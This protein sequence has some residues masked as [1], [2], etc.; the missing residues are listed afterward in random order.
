MQ[1]HNIRR[2]LNWCICS[3]GALCSFVGAPTLKAQC[4]SPTAPL[5]NVRIRGGTIFAGLVDFGLTN[6]ICFGIEFEDNEFLRSPINLELPDATGLTAIRS[7]IKAHPRYS[8]ASDGFLSVRAR[9]KPVATWLDFRIHRFNVQRTDVQDA[10]N[11]LN[12]F[13]EAQIKPGGGY[14]G[15]FASWTTRIWWVLSMK[16]TEPSG[17]C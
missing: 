9:A 4:A 6:K 14:A 3:V 7:A 11:V 5:G 12:M 1:R 17:N 16:K 13:L 10:S 8:V 15:T 2:T